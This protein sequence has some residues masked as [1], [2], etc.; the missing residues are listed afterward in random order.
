MYFK[1]PELSLC[2]VERR[3]HRRKQMELLHR[4][5]AFQYVA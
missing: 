2:R 4:M 5:N 1:R 3:L